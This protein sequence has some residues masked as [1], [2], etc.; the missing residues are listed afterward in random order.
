[1]I[2]LIKKIKKTFLYEIFISYLFYP[3]YHFL[4]KNIINLKARLL[5]IFLKD[6]NEYFS[7]GK[8]DKI[9]IKNNPD[10]EN[11]ASEIKDESLKKIPDLKKKL[12]SEDYKSKILSK[13]KAFGELPYSIDFYDDLSE[14][15]KSKIVKFAASKKMINTAA[16]YM[17]IYPMITRIQVALNIPRENSSA[18]SAMLW[19]KDVF[20]FK[21]LDFFMAVTDIDENSGPFYCLENRVKAGTFK[22]FP[23]QKSK[24]GERGKVSFAEFDRVFEGYK[25]IPLIGKSGTAFFLD[26]FSTYHRGGFCKSK[27]RLVLRICYQSHDV[28][29]DSYQRNDD[30]FLFDK[31]IKKYDIKDKYHRYLFFNKP[32]YTMKILSKL[33]MKFFSII[34]F[35]Y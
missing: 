30:Y 12:L 19:H 22:N 18:R 17:G 2:N 7:L 31:S 5:F 10:F 4:W 25:T 24:S 23:Y 14:S 1:M 26:S 13:N 11:L 3:F 6:K 32:T 9:L 33:L 27:D 34:E 15:L 20:G 21:N 35:K 16:N 29:H 28:V 8:N